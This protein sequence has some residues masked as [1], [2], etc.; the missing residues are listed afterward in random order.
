MRIV[1]VSL[2][3]LLSVPAA[4]QEGISGTILGLTGDK[5]VKIVWG[6]DDTASGDH[7]FGGSNIF[8]LYGYDTDDDTIR[9]IKSTLDDYT[10]P[11]ITYDGERIV[12]SDR[13]ERKVFVV[14]W[15][16]SGRQQI[17]TGF[18]GA[19]WYDAAGGKEW[20]YFQDG[21]DG[22]N[23]PFPLRRTNLD[24]PAE[25]E[26]VWDDTDTNAYWMSISA[27]GARIASS[28]PWPDCGAVVPRY[29]GSGGGDRYTPTTGYYDN[30]CWTTVTPDTSYRVGVFDGP[31]RAWKVW[32]WPPGSMRTLNL[33][34]APGIDGWEIYHPKMSNHPLFLTM[35]GPYSNGAMG[36]NNIG[37]GGP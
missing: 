33:H 37:A 12:Y 8:R 28:W 31:H 6:Q 27:D 10:K 11:L 23:D 35:T 16:G 5:R 13:V 9:A 34:S 18:A 20:V 32:D 2:L 7:V 36:D 29:D 26:L 4:A 21:G 19:V 30:G 1:V 3:L 24:N 25:V 17:A 22:D 14:D 15:D